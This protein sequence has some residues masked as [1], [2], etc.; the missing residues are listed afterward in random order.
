MERSEA[1]KRADKNYYLK[2]KAA[3]TRGYFKVTLRADEMK[4]INDAIKNAGMTQPEFIRKAY[5]A[6][7]GEKL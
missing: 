5:E 7:F 6:I 2:E 4:K 3:K 1:Q